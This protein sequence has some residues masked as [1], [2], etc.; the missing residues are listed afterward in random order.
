MLNILA[1][2]NACMDFVESEGARVESKRKKV[3]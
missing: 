2:S 1:T 3:N